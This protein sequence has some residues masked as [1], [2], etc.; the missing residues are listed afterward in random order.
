MLGYHFTLVFVL[1]T[2]SDAQPNGNGKQ[3]P[4]SKAETLNATVGVHAEAKVDSIPHMA[5]WGI[6]IYQESLCGERNHN[7]KVGSES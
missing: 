6:V 4:L 2:F 5:I 1:I 7:S 3:S